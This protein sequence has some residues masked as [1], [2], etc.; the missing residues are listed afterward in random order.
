MYSM[1]NVMH[2]NMNVI[3]S[4]MHSEWNIMHNNNDMYSSK[5]QLNGRC[6]QEYTLKT[7]NVVAIA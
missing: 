7:I 1:Y 2:Y 3:C 5:E 4:L 6:N